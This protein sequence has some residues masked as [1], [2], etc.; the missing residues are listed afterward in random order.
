MFLCFFVL[1]NFAFFSLLHLSCGRLD[2]NAD[3]CKT[4]DLYKTTSSAVLFG[5]FFIF[6]L[7]F[8]P[9]VTALPSMEFL[10]L[11]SSFWGSCY[12]FNRHNWRKQPTRQLYLGSFLSSTPSLFS[13]ACR[14]FP[15][16]PLLHRKRP[17]KQFN[18]IQFLAYLS[19]LCTLMYIRIFDHVVV[20]SPHLK[21][22][23]R[24]DRGAPPAAVKY[25]LASSRGR[26]GPQINVASCGGLCCGV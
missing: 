4:N 9:K 7:P 22:A 1:P 12:C 13:S 5:P 2:K 17:Q 3:Y 8:N 25:S 6:H 19:D 18:S 11:Q 10:H 26:R 20:R 21:I 24:G 15:W 16:D 14:V 23:S